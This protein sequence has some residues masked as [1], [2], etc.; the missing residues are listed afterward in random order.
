M[1]VRGMGPLQPEKHIPPKRIYRKYET[2]SINM[3]PPKPNSLE[4]QM[5]HNLP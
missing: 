3:E 5:G 4:K 2:W 1:I